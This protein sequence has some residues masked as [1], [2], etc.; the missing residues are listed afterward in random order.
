MA[1][2][3]VTTIRMTE[4][5]KQ[6]EEIIVRYDNSVKRLKDIGGELDL[7]WEGD[8]SNKF[9]EKLGQDQVRFAQLKDLLKAYT[10]TLRQDAGIYEKAERD[11]L[12]VL[13]TNKTR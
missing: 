12:E 9:M 11:V 1:G 8:A 3:E 10:E 6:V 5:A 7:M 2:T 13:N 4:V